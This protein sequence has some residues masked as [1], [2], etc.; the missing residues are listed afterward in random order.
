MVAAR[1]HVD[2]VVTHSKVFIFAFFIVI[3]ANAEA[4]TGFYFEVIHLF[5]VNLWDRRQFAQS[6]AAASS[7]RSPV[8]AMSAR[9]V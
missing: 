6:Q 3:V 4:V 5:V 7:D 9:A 2:T 1:H 8:T